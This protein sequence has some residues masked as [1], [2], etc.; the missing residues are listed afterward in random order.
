MTF[1]VTIT[2]DASLDINARG[3]IVQQVIHNTLKKLAERPNDMGVSFVSDER[4][5]CRLLR[6]GSYRILYKT[7]DNE[8]TVLRVYP[9]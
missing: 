5:D 2:E 9:H 8:V 1:T 7:M 3:A 4:G 6:R